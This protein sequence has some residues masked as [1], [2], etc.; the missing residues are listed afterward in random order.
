VIATCPDSG[1]KCL[2]YLGL[3]STLAL[4]FAC[5]C[6]FKLVISICAS[7]DQKWLMILVSD[8]KVQKEDRDNARAAHHIKQRGRRTGPVRYTYLEGLESLPC[9][10]DWLYEHVRRQRD[11]DFPVPSEIVRLCFPPAEKAYSYT[12]MWAYG[13]YYRSDIE[14]G[15]G[16][17]TFDSGI[18]TI[19]NETANT[20]IDVG[21]LKSIVAVQY[22]ATT[23]CL[24]KG[25]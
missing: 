16:H 23:V 1:P 19:S 6:C 20:M 9:F 2:Q 22:A 4:G 10:A 3:V 18:A 24:M 14:Q 8:Y 15:P 21:V 11:E 13:S 17:V 12:A 25:S 5:E 7:V